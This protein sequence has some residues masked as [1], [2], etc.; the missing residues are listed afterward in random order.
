MAM[1]QPPQMQQNLQ[2]FG[3]MAQG[4]Q[5]AHQPLMTPQEMAQ[6]GRYGDQVI[7]HLTPGEIAVPPQV[8]TPQIKK[9]LAQA[10]K[11]AGVPPSNFVAGSPTS[12]VNPAT[13]APEYS[14]WA[15]ILPVLGAI[16]GAVAAPYTGGLSVPA[17]M[18]IGGAAGG[19][20]G[21]LM[22]H[23]SATQIA[24]QAL[25]GGAGGYLGGAMSG[26][27]AAAGAGAGAA[28]DA[29]P[30][31][32]DTA[33]AAAANP[34]GSLNASEATFG[35]QAFNASQF[36]MNPSA[37]SSPAVNSQTFADMIK[38][39]PV[40]GAMTAGIGSSLGSVLAPQPVQQPAVPPGFNTPMA[41]LNRNWQAVRGNPGQS[42]TP[43]FAGYNPVASVTGSPYQF[44]P[45]AAS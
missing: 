9:D 28:A 2:A 40:K 24:L 16:G 22:D 23:G 26:A 4:A 7:A 44:Y 29:G 12:S 43:S 36:G 10:F 41:P 17:G 11:H 42:S 13:G 32:T 14:L 38:N 37:L 34:A 21:G 3:R 20:A 19:A 35:P 15:S 31:I 30:A 1:P 8:Q 5:G 39:L 25:G 33:T 6:L 27:G 18:A 45:Q